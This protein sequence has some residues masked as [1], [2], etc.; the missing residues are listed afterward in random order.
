[1]VSGTYHLS[2]PTDDSQTPPHKGLLQYAPLAP[3]PRIFSHMRCIV[4]EKLGI[5][6]PVKE[7]I[8]VGG[9]LVATPIRPTF[10]N[11]ILVGATQPAPGA[12]GTS[13]SR[14]SYHPRP[15]PVMKHLIQWSQIG[16][17]LHC[18]WYIGIE[19]IIYDLPGTIRLLFV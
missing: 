19:A 15:R 9:S 4:R 13:F 18:W 7:I 10:H 11:P 1:M 14:F 3:M 17:L 6:L 2:F 12:R 16:V 5:V 8:E